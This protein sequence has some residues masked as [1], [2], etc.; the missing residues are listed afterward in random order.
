FLL[1]GLALGVGG[2]VGCTYNFAAGHYQ[3][4]MRAFARGDLDDARAGQV[5]A[6]TMIQVLGRYGFLAAS[7]AV[8]GLIG[9]DC[10]PVR[11]PLRTLTG[12]ERMSLA[13]ELRSFDGFSR[14]FCRAE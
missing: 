1:A 3:R 11:P 13:E 10:G 8:M 7:K 14:P 4:L 6:A 9:V 5:Q 2:A 12:E